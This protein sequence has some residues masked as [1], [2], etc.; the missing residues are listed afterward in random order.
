[1]PLLTAS[2][3][4]WGRSRRTQAPLGDV[5]VMGTPVGHLAAGILVPPAE[6][7]VAASRMIGDVRG[8]PCQ[9]SQSS[10]SGARDP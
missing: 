4:D 7:V 1:M 6:L 5:V 10:P 8:L 2:T 3:A 9:K